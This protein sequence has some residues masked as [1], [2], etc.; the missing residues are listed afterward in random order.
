MFGEDEGFINSFTNHCLCR[1]GLMPKRSPAE[2]Q[3]NPVPLHRAC[4]P[5]ARP[6]TS[7]GDYMESL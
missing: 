6:G 5:T 1:R 7:R 2:Q 4:P 3:R